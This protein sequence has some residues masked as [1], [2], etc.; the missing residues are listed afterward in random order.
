MYYLNHKEFLRKMKLRYPATIEAGIKN[1]IHIY[2]EPVFN[3]QS[4]DIG[5][6]F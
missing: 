3:K 6:F 5:D 4:N 1:F 2:L